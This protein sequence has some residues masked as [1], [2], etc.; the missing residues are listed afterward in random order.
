VW[1]FYV[2]T[3]LNKEITLFCVVTRILEV[4]DFY[5]LTALNKEITLFC[6]VTVC[7]VADS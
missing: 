4:W 2:L 7:S 6:V 3:A 1:D 5:V